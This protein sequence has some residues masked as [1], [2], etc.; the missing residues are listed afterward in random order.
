[1]GRKTENTGFVCAVCGREVRPVTNGSYRN[2]CPFCLSSVHVDEKP[3]DR[4]S[5]CGGTMDAIGVLY[6][7]KKGWQLLHRCRKCGFE[8]KNMAAVNTDQPDSTEAI[9]ALMGDRG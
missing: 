7:P 8:G 2:H 6:N 5:A 9:S 1:M 3:G 4:Q